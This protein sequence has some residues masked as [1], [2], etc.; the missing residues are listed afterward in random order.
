MIVSQALSKINRLNQNIKSNEKEIETY[1]KSGLDTGGSYLDV[2]RKVIIVN[3]Q[4][5]EQFMDMKLIGNMIVKD[6]LAKIDIINKQIESDKTWLKNN[7]HLAINGDILPRKI[8]AIK[9]N[10]KYKEIEVVALLNLKL[11]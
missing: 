2:L 5:V 9:N 3:K 11:I 8:L 10:I 7:E 1:D 6:S 4:E